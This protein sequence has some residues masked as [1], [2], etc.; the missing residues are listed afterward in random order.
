MTTVRMHRRAVVWLALVGMGFATASLAFDIVPPN[1]KQITR[2]QCPLPK[3]RFIF[4]PIRIVA[5]GFG[6][7]KSKG[8]KFNLE[9]EIYPPQFG[10][11]YKISFDYVSPLKDH[12]ITD[13]IL[14]ALGVANIGGNGNNPVKITIKDV[15]ANPPGIHAVKVS[16]F[17]GEFYHIPATATLYFSTD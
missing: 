15:E 8:K 11:I 12:D 16:V 3:T 13:K 17:P 4:T 14:E 7:D 5:P 1:A 6:C 2:K 10:S 9:L